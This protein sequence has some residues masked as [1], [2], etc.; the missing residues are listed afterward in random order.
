MKNSDVASL[1]MHGLQRAAVTGFTAEGVCLVAVEL[2]PNDSVVPCDLL[3][4]TDLGLLRLATGDAVMVWLPTN[5]SERGVIFGRIGPSVV[6][7]SGL[8]PPDHLVLEAKQGLTLQCGEGSITLR[9]D[10]KVLIKGKELISRAEG[11]NRIK[12][13]SVAIN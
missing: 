3:Q 7:K 11:M 1:C 8:E 2:I 10:G 13:A 5:T 4:T 9:G 6:S 12:G